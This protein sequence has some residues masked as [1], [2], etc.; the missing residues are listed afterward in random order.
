MRF[1]Q[2]VL[3]K[4]S[5]P[6]LVILFWAKD[7]HCFTYIQVSYL[8]SILFL[9]FGTDEF[10]VLVRN[11]LVGSPPEIVK[12]NVGPWNLFFDLLQHV[13]QYQYKIREIR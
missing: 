6:N 2:F 9:V 3:G 7:N 13:Y 11:V 5:M 1:S 10:E 8:F 4:Y 12:V